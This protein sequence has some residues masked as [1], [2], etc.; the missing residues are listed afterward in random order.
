MNSII[1][2]YLMMI[3]SIDNPVYTLGDN[4]LLNIYT[5]FSHYFIVCIYDIDI[6][7]FWCFLDVIFKFTFLF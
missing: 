3:V 6:S 1:S 5:V 2:F 4:K 7:Q